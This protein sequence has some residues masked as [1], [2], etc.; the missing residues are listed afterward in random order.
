MARHYQE[1]LLLA[2]ENRKSLPFGYRGSRLQALCS[3]FVTRLV[4]HLRRGFEVCREP[5]CDTTKAL[6]DSDPLVRDQEA[7]VSNP[8]AR[9]FFSTAYLGFWSF[10]LHNSKTLV[11]TSDDELGSG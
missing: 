2:D 3:V 9:P 6:L 11:T 1:R 10:H 7:G 4:T 5:S 8:L